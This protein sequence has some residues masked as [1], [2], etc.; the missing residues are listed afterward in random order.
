M[1]NFLAA[2]TLGDSY[3]LVR[4]MTL[5]TRMIAHHPGVLID[6]PSLVVEVPEPVLKHLQQEV[7]ETEI[8]VGQVI[9]IRLRPETNQGV[10]E[11]DPTGVTLEALLTAQVPMTMVLEETI[12]T[13]DREIATTIGPREIHRTLREYA[14]TPE[15]DQISPVVKPTVN[16]KMEMT[17]TRIITKQRY[18]V[19]TKGSFRTE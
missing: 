7:L 16:G 18:C 11:D 8:I 4:V 14:E 3:D 2:R 13:R 19:V 15:R 10:R 5:A 6:L 17:F 12:G 1:I 9:V